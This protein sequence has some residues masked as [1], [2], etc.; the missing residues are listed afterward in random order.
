[1]KKIVILLM[2]VFTFS[3]VTFASFP[4]V[5]NDSVELVESNDNLFSP[6]SKTLGMLLGF[7]LGIFG[8]LIAYVMDD[9]EMI[10]G[11][12]KGLMWAVILVVAI[13]LTII[14]LWVGGVAVMS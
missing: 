5:Q 2:T 10:R 9:D 4:V 14:A 11:A 1:M 8:V 12:W 3:N 7:F 6:D 13:Y